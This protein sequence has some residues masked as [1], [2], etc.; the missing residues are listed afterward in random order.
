[1]HSS[2]N[3]LFQKQS[4]TETIK[5]LFDEIDET[6]LART[7]HVS[8]LKRQP[9]LM[10]SQM[11]ERQV[12]YPQQTQQTRRQ[13]ESDV[14]KQPAYADQSVGSPL[15]EV[16]AIQD[17]QGEELTAW[18]DD[19]KADPDF[20]PCI[21]QATT[22]KKR[23]RNLKKLSDAACVPEEDEMDADTE[24]RLERS[25]KKRRHSTSSNSTPTKSPV[26]LPRVAVLIDEIF[27]DTT[28]QQS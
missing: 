27:P 24:T 22:P 10:L 13:P 19:L 3:K 20:Q 25:A 7:T 6:R 21:S 16:V 26:V 18:M 12:K 23:K 11:L 8:Y 15:D 9:G 28:Q 14:D 5:F 17:E 1:M 2:T 4:N